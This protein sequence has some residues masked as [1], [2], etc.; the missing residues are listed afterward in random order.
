[1]TAKAGFGAALVVALLCGAAAGEVCTTQSQM[2]P[3]QRSALVQA[4]LDF[5]RRVQGGDSSGVRSLTIAQYA[6][7]FGGIAGAIADTSPKIKGSAL[8]VESIYLLDASVLK[9]TANGTGAEAAQFFCSLNQTAAETQFLIPGLPPGQYAFAVVSV[10]GNAPWQLSFLFQQ[11]QGQWKMAGFYPKPLTAA[12]HDGLWYWTTARTLVKQ[13]HLWSGWLYYL[14][15]EMLLRPAGFVTST[16]FEKLRAEQSA[17]APPALSEGVSTEAPLVVKGKGEAEY[18]FTGLATDDSFSKE[19]IDVMAHLKVDQM[20]DAAA[21]RQHNIEA[22]SALLA[23]YP[24]L[25]QNFHGVWIIAEAA[26]QS[27]VATELSMAE[28]PS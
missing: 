6:Q 20:G 7:D 28:I 26:G 27:P 22:M 12:G 2:Q 18:H 21:A 3:A 17:D 19:N 23:A 16:H 24:E 10:A 1:M 9:P 15:A 4:A 14:Q 25:R 13:K 5:A 11:E 8:Q